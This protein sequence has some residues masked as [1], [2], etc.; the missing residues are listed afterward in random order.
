MN[1]ILPSLFT[2]LMPMQT[3]RWLGTTNTLFK[4]CLKI[5]VGLLVQTQSVSLN[6]RLDFLCL[7]YSAFSPTDADD[8]CKVTRF[9]LCKYSKVWL[10]ININGAVFIFHNVCL[11]F[12][13]CSFIIWWLLLF[14]F[15][16]FFLFFFPTGVWWNR[17]L[18][19]KCLSRSSYKDWKH[20]WFW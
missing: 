8:A 9:C 12:D 13:A 1:C 19:I 2:Q 4:S 5:E 6:S 7:V 20:N 18:S 14:F 10:F 16:F 3:F 17:N 15:T 11:G